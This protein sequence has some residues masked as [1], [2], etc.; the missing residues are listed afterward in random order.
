MRAR[1][2]SSRTA[3]AI[4]ARSIAQEWLPASSKPSGE[5]KRVQARPRSPARSFIRR[6]KA[7]TVPLTRWASAMAASLPDGSSSPLSIVSSLMRL[8]LGS[9]PTAEPL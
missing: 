4:S 6:T 9:T 5:L 2:G 3:R 8:P 7:A 1:R